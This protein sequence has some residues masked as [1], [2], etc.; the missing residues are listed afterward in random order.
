[1][2]N[3]G[4][5]SDPACEPVKVLTETDAPKADTARSESNSVG[6]SRPKWAMELN[7]DGTVRT[8]YTNLEL[9]GGMPT[10]APELVAV[11][12]EPGQNEFRSAATMSNGRKPMYIVAS[13]PVSDAAAAEVFFTDLG[14]KRVLY[15]QG[16]RIVE[17]IAEGEIAQIEPV[18]I[19][20]LR[21]RIEK[22]GE[23]YAYRK[24]GEN[25]MLA[26]HA[27]ISE[28]TAKA[29]HASDAARRC[30][31]KITLVVNCPLITNYAL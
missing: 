18:S 3:P 21:T 20:G 4:L 23:L 19:S 17:V 28:E 25:Y 5:G 1:M 29:L 22:L 6:T 8:D 2:D 26:R 9:P 14:K 27:R 7:P 16:S 30:L 13:G 15:C 11:C 31:P 10:N 24:R 12:A